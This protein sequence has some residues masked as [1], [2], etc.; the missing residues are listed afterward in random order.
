[1]LCSHSYLKVD[2]RIEDN[3]Q[4]Y[5]ENEQFI[6]MYHDRITTASDIFYLKD[7]LDI[8]FK[9]MSGKKGF[10]YLHTTRGVYPYLTH[11]KPD[12]ILQVYKEIKK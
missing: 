6:R 1:M 11:E 3:E 2:R 12:R 9:N 5:E 7:V 4:V 8:T 10:L